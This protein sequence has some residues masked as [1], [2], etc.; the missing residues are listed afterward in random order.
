MKDVI[1]ATLFEITTYEKQRTYYNFAKLII[2]GHVHEASKKEDKGTNTTPSSTAAKRA[3][4]LSALRSQSTFSKTI[5]TPNGTT[6]NTTG[7]ST[8]GHAVANHCDQTATKPLVSRQMSHQ[9]RRTIMTP[10]RKCSFSSV[11]EFRYLADGGKTSKTFL[12]SL[13][14]PSPTTPTTTDPPTTSLTLSSSITPPSASTR[15]AKYGRNGDSTSI[16]WSSRDT[17]R[18]SIFA[19]YVPTNSPYR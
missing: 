12:F 14:A 13:E 17:D 15:R 19:G 16:E 3:P 11:S 6:G 9:D 10:K 18:S 8:P 7:S 2:K 1:V 5:C 4:K